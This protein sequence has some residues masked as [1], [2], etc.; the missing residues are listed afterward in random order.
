MD[1]VRSN[2]SNQLFSLATDVAFIVMNVCYWVSSS[3]NICFLIFDVILR[4]KKR[5]S[6]MGSSSRG[7]HP[8]EYGDPME[9]NHRS[10]RRV[11]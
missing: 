3:Y 4:Y 11:R 9:A 2:P 5:N 8:R 1:M 6:P 10:G 7:S